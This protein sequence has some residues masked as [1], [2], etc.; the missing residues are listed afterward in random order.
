MVGQIA[1]TIIRLEGWERNSWGY[2]GL[3]NLRGGRGLLLILLT[4]RVLLQSIE[5]VFLLGKSPLEVSE[6]MGELWMRARWR[7]G[8]LGMPRVSSSPRY[9]WGSCL[10]QL[11]GLSRFVP[12]PSQVGGGLLLCWQRWGLRRTTRF[13]L[14]DAASLEDKAASGRELGGLRTWGGET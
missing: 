10:H 2:L 13:A 1:H 3:Q 9:D 7:W 11:I 8:A 12:P 14:D 4:H 6:L 5:C